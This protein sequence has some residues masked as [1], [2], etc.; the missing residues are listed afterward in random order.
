MA[1]TE[2][3]MLPF[4]NDSTSLE[5]AMSL[6]ESLQRLEALVLRVV[7]ENVNAGWRGM[8]AEAIA[9]ATGLRMQSATARVRGLVLKGELRDSGERG[10]NASGR[11]AII[12][13]LGDGVPV[14]ERE[15]QTHGR[16]AAAVRRTWAAAADMVEQE[17]VGKFP[18]VTEALRRVADRMRERGRCER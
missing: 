10:T 7:R 16:L 3:M 6:R 13:T 15:A 1:T 4:S 17:S 2:V 14:D 5:A 11:K 18:E 12:W 9:A 8:T